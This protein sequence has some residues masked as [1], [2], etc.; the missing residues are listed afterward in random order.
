M[1]RINLL[2]FRAARKKENVRRQVSIFFLSLI[3]VTI[4]VVSYNAILGNKIS[5]LN[6]E[7]EETKA[8]VAKYNKINQEIA[9]IKQ[10]LAVLN[11]KIEVIQTLDQNRK[12]PV[13][14]LEAMTTLIVPERMW[15]TDFASND[16]SVNLNGI[17]LDN[18]TVADFMTRIENSESYGSV[19]LSSI[20]KQAIAEKSLSL[21][22]FGLS[23]TKEMK[24]ANKEK[25]EQ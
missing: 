6:A 14:L 23:F 10:K 3:L 5:K 25:A 22:S 17:A 13:Q 15:L 19:K 11:K 21:K 1:I 7:I 16:A 2:P 8:Q 4:I 18:Q 24:P 12:A 9:E 20:R